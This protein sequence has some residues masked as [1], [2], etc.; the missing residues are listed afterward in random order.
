MI[1]YLKCKCKSKDRLL[2]KKLEDQGYQVRIAK[3]SLDVQ[4]QIS[5]YKQV[6]PFV[7]ERGVARPL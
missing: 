5:R 1:A 4:R 2:A 3:G 6:L 7:V